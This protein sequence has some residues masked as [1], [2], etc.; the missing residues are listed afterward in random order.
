MLCHYCKEKQ[1]KAYLVPPGED[2]FGKWS[3]RCNWCGD[4][5][6]EFYKSRLQFLK[7]KEEL[8]NLNLV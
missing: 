5:K 4:C 2:I 1:I 3:V 6:P 8:L 7:V